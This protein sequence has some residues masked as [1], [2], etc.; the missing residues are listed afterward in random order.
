MR[1][2][3][4]IQNCLLYSSLK[5]MRTGDAADAGYRQSNIAAST[6]NGAAEYPDNQ[7]PQPLRNAN[8]SALIF[9]AC[10]VGIP[11]GKSLYVIRVPFFNSFADKGPAAT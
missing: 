5:T 3:Q 4:F 1:I 2:H 9:S 11:C 8:R 6:L 7:Y 10:V